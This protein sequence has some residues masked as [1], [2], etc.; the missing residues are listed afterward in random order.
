M[1]KLALTLGFLFLSIT[2]FSQTVVNYESKVIS[3]HYKSRGLDIKYNPYYNEEKDEQELVMS[4]E[5]EYDGIEYIYINKDNI[6]YLHIFVYEGKENYKKFKK[7]ASKKG[8]RYSNS[9][10]KEL[11]KE[12]IE[13]TTFSSEEEKLK[14]KK[15]FI[16][17]KKNNRRYG[18]NNMLKMKRN[19]YI[20]FNS[21][22]IYSISYK[23]KKTMLKIF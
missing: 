10:I 9:E 2:L 6:C 14:F 15:N 8:A 18:Y 20:N 16:E 1:K 11:A 17:E 5:N 22:L 21:R 13:D 23:D 3:K 12:T 7:M 4:I 19:L